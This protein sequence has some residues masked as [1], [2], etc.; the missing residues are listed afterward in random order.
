MRQTGQFKAVVD[1]AIVGFKKKVTI[2]F[3]KQNNTKITRDTD[4]N[5]KFD[6]DVPNGEYYVKAFVTKS[7][8][9]NT[10]DFRAGLLFVVNAQTKIDALNLWI[11]GGA[12]EAKDPMQDWWLAQFAAAKKNADDAKAVQQSMT[13][14]GYVST[15]QVML[16][17]LFGNPANGKYYTVDTDATLLS[18]TPENRSVAYVE[19]VSSY[20][21]SG[22]YQKLIWSYATQTKKTYEI[23]KENGIWQSAIEV[24]TSQGFTVDSNGNVK[25]ASPIIKMNNSGI[26]H[27]G[28]DHIIPVFEKLD[29]GVYKI[30]GTDGLAKGE[31]PGDWYI[32]TPKD[33]NGLPYF[34]VEWE[35]DKENNVI[36]KCFARQFDPDIGDFVNGLPVD[37]GLNQR[38]IDLRFHEVI[39]E[40]EALKMIK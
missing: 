29:I 38:W 24:L 23:R 22:A 6:F 9:K 26:K 33:K 10:Y 34:M 5:G 16:A 3:T 25:K 32:E 30:S 20:H 19:V 39:V 18:L 11:G 28:F 15:K 1:G 12:V 4:D 17:Y 13:E 40:R 8:H 21:A 36:I 7:E 37:I 2:I 31:Y 14:N 27:S 35:Q